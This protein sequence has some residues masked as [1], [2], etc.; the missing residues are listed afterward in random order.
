MRPLEELITAWRA[1]PD[2]DA[3]IA[4]CSH[5]GSARREE[6]A[7]AAVQKRGTPTTAR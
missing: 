6:L 5:L 4:L 7:S 1:N 3:T 2:A